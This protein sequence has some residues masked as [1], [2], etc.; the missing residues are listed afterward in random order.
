MKKSF[1][2]S[3]YERVLVLDGAMG[4]MLQERGLKPGSSP[5]E[6]NLTA[7]EVV[8]DVHREYLEAGADI[9]VTNTFGGSSAKLSHFGL[10]ERVYEINAKG[11]ALA[12]EAAGNSAYVAASMGP[13][14]RFVEPV[15]DCSFDE[16][17]A[18]FREQ[19]LPLIEAGADLITLETFLDIKEARAA[20]I[21]IRGIKL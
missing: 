20:V 21:A 12:R 15:G 3:I 14:G 5:E 13:T 6:M 1:L 17:R 7:P 16:M 4:T 2:Q 18:I 11:V 9:I 10:A 19:A 8:A